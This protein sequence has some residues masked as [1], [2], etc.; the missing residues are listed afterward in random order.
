MRLKLFFLF[1][2]ALNTFDQGVAQVNIKDSTIA[3]WGI[4][5]QVGVQFPMAD[6]ADRFGTNAV[7][8]LGIFKKLKSN[9]IIGLNGDFLFG[10]E[11]KEEGLAANIRTANGEFLDIDGRIATVLIQERGIEAYLSL[12]KIFTMNKPNPNSGLLVK[13]GGGF[14]LH[15]IRFEA[16]ENEVAAIEG[17]N[18]KG[19]DRLTSGLVFNQF[20]G[21]QFFGNSN[22]VNFFVGLEVHEG[23]TQGRR[24]YNFD[25]MSVDDDPRFDMLIGLRGGWVL[26]IYTKAADEYLLY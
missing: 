2:I 18:S 3:L 12:G 17:D 10:S 16:R 13:L 9:Y 25:T 4:A 21:Y 24:S 22:R 1:I 19:Y 11:V 23:F 20:F 7:T 8:G 15:R 5:P 14:L 26:P 6:M